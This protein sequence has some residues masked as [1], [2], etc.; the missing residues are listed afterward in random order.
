MTDDRFDLPADADERT[1]LTTFLDWHRSVLERKCTG[2]SDEQLRTAAVPTTDVTLLGLL[3][4]MA[5]VEAWYF[6][7]VIEGT[8][9]PDL[10]DDPS[11]FGDLASMTGD[12]AFTLWREQV[13][14]GRKVL[15]A[16]ELDF[17][18]HNPGRDLDQSLRWVCNHMI[19]EYARHNGHADLIREA[20]D[21][22]TG[23]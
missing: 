7:N 17:V 9:V 4:H 6:R 13:E 22:E 3:R 23:E 20:I 11:G 19:D 14:I 5:A 12:E 1:T 21:G 15:A 16:H 10:F 8:D 2:L 18:A